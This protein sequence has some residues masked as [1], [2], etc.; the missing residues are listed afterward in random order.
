MPADPQLYDVVAVNLTTY[1]ERD[2]KTGLT[3]RNAEAVICMCV[4]RR[5]VDEEIFKLVTHKGDDDAR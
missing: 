2:I 3:A 4:A 1:A 5:G